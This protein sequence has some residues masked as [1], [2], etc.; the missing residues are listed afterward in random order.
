MMMLYCL[1]S[2]C[3]LF[4]TRSSLASQVFGQRQKVHIQIIHGLL[5]HAY[6]LGEQAITLVL[7]IIMINP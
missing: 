4:V 6:Q 7:S 3:V 1:V 2:V 5:S